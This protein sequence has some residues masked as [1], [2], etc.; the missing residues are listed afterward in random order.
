LLIAVTKDHAGLSSG[1]EI[2]GQSPIFLLVLFDRDEPVLR[3]QQIRGDERRARIKVRAEPAHDI[4]IGTKNTGR[5]IVLENSAHARF[6]LGSFERFAT[7][8]IL[9]A[10][11]GIGVDPPK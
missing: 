10:A 2:G 8:K 7:L 3:P 1:S 5:G 4:E 9:E 11:P 6:S